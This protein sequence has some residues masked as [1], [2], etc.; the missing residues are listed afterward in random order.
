MVAGCHSPSSPSS[1]GS[2]SS[3]GSLSITLTWD[4]T[5]DLDLHVLEPSNTEIWWGNLGPTASG[6]VMDGDADQECRTT[7]AGHKEIVHWPSAAPNGV[8]T[9]RLDYYDNC[10]ASAVTYTLNITDGKTTLPAISA[11][12]TGAG[13]HGNGPIQTIKTFTRSGNSL[14]LNRVNM[15]DMLVAA[16]LRL[17]SGAPARSSRAR[18]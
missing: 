6:G 10:N 4:V 9:V 15:P 7:T 2:D 5:A 17:A 11:T 8:Y 12:L 18:E 14:S 16:S 1:G 13:D 3:S